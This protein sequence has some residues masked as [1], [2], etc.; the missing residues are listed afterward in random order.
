M[1][2]ANKDILYSM[3]NSAQGYVAAWIGGK[4]EGEG[5]YAYV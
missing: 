2:S 3:W 5:I 4:C 1:T